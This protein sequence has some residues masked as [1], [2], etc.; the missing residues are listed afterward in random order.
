MQ[1]EHLFSAELVPF[2]QAYIHRNWPNGIVFRDIVEL[3]E[4]IVSE[5]GD[6]NVK[7]PKFDTIVKRFGLDRE[8]EHESK[9]LQG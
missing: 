8:T 6:E 4:G 5:S 2:K 1:H 7:R 9:P 3:A